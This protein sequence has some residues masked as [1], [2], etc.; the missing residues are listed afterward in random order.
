MQNTAELKVRPC[1]KVKLAG[2]IKQR[3][4][5]SLPLSSQDELTAIAIT[6]NTTC[7]RLFFILSVG[8]PA[9]YGV[10]RR[11]EYVYREMRVCLSIPPR[12]N[13]RVTRRTCGHTKAVAGRLNPD[14]LSARPLIFLLSSDSSPFLSLP[15]PGQPIAIVVVLLFLL[16]P[17]LSSDVRVRPQHRIRDR[18]DSPEMIRQSLAYY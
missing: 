10:F 18:N 14:P 15:F 17:S 2:S 6:T 9:T 11:I 5:S 4:A 7:V 12:T 16:N 1:S 8:G 3:R 13:D